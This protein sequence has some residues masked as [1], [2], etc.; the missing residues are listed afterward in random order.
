MVNGP[1]SDDD[2]P[3]HWKT[4]TLSAVAA[5]RPFVRVD[6]EIGAVD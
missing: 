4:R 3:L 2:G 1:D 6:D 5:G